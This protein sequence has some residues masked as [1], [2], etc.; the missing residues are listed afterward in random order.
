MPDTPFEWASSV[1]KIGSAE[2]RRAL[3]EWL[4]DLAVHSE[5]VDELLLVATELAAKLRAEI[6]PSS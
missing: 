4:E 2:M 1:G 6:A 3:R 5:R